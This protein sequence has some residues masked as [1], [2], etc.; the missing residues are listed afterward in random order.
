MSDLSHTTAEGLPF[1]SVEVP[2][3][4]GGAIRYVL[5]VGLLPQYLSALMDAYVP[6]GIIGSI[7]DR[8]GILITRRPFVDGVEL[9]GQPTIPELRQHLGEPSALWIKAMSRSGVPTY[10]SFFRSE[11]TGWSVSMAL[12]RDAVDGPWRRTSV[13]FAA[14][15]L[16]ALLASLLFARLVAQPL[17]SA[18]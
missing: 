7:I 8:K 6:S 4:V 13:L 11:R 14:A 5:A 15:G 17:P 2:V 16:A 18:R 1:I 3:R 9:V 12:P 10:T